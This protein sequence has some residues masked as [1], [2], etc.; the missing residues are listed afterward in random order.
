[1]ADNTTQ[2]IQRKSKGLC[3]RGCNRPTADGR[4]LCRHCT[5]KTSWTRLSVGKFPIDLTLNEFTFWYNEKTSKCNGLC[6]W[7]G[8]PFGKRGAVVDHDT[9]DLRALICY[10][11]N[12]A[13]SYG[14]DRLKKIISALDKSWQNA[15]VQSDKGLL[16]M[17]FTRWARLVQNA[18]TSERKDKRMKQIVEEIRE[19]YQ[20]EEDVLNCYNKF[21]EFL[22]RNFEEGN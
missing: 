3:A 15:E 2:Y 20:S 21:N 18:N 19:R 12:I 13:E 6:E 5:I 10:R 22:D 9:G 14:I 4:V 7:C 1:M 16:D 8:E 17:A 11:C